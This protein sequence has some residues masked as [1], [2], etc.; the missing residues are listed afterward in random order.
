MRKLSF[1]STWR[2]E[3][4]TSAIELT[5]FYKPLTVETL[6]QQPA[7]STADVFG[8]LGG[9]MG[10]FLGASL[11]SCIENFGAVLSSDPQL[12]QGLQEILDL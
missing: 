4:W 5:I 8:K 2:Q 7:V 6:K 10:L 3:L 12:F 9:Q 1:H 11:L